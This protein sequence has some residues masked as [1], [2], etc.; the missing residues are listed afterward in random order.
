MSVT[1]NANLSL[2]QA[3]VK[4]ASKQVQSALNSVNINPK[5]LDKFGGALG[6][7]T[8]NA[9]EFQKSM[10]AATARVFA[11]GATAAVIQSI[12]QSFKA[13]VSTTIE[14]EKRLVEINTIFGASEQTFSR[15]RESIFQ[16]AK[17]TGQAFDVVAEG[18][19]ELARQGLNAEETA[20]RLNAA[21]VLTR[22]SGLDSVSSV[23]ALTAAINGFTSASLDATTIVNKL[24]AVDTA[25]AVS[26]KDLAD[27]FQRAG[28]TAEDAGVSFD[29]LLGI[30]TAVQQ[31]TSRGGAVI[32]NAL[33]SIFT[34]LSRSTTISELQELGVQIDANQ[35]G[36][37]KLK[38][39]SAALENVS[40]PTV[41]SQIKELAGGVFQINV[42]SAALKD[43]SNE[44]SI[45]AGA[46][47]KAAGAT[48]EAFQKNKDLNQTLSAQINSLVAG[49]TNL[50]EK[51][52]SITLSPLLGD[53]INIANNITDFF[54][55]ALSE[56]NGN[57]FVK[58]FFAGIGA[59]IKGPGLILIT[60]AFLNIFKLVSKFALDGFKELTK[61]GKGSEKIKNIEQGIIQ[62][63][64]Q[65]KGLRE[66]LAN[67]SL[68]QAQKEEL[69]IKAI[70]QENNLLREQQRIVTALAKAAAARGVGGFNAG[71][72]FSGKRGKNFA[73]GFV[74]SF[75]E[76][77][78]EQ[79]LASSHGYKAGKVRKRRMFDGQGGSFAGIY[80]DAE[81][82]TDVTMGGKKGTFVIPPNGFAA[83]GFVPNFAIRPAGSPKDFKTR[84]EALKAGFSGAQVGRVFGPAPKKTKEKRKDPK[85]I[86][87]VS[88]SDLGV[89][90]LFSEAKSGTLNGTL[91]V[92]DY[93]KIKKRSLIKPKAL[94]DTISMTGIQVRSLGQINKED[95]APKS[96]SQNID[97][98]FADPLEKFAKQIGDTLK[99]SKQDYNIKAAIDK[100]DSQPS[101]LFTTGVQ[102]QLFESAARIAA[103]G[104][105]NAIK[106]FEGGASE[107]KP[108]DFEENSNALASLAEAFQ[109]NSPLLKADA[110]RTG[111]SKAANSIIRKALNDKSVRNKKAGLKS[112][113]KASGYV[114][115]FFNLGLNDA[116]KR[117]TT[118][119]G[120][121]PSQVRVGQDKAFAASSNPAG[122]AVTNTRD[123]PN[124]ISDVLA[125]SGYVPNFIAGAGI[126]ALAKFGTKN[127]AKN[128][129]KSAGKSAGKKPPPLPKTGG[130]MDGE[131]TPKTGGMM[132]GGRGVMGMMALSQI[133]GALTTGSDKFN[134]FLS[135][136]KF[137]EINEE[138]EKSQELL[139]EI[140]AQ[141]GKGSEEYEKQSKI[142]QGLTKDLKAQKGATNLLGGVASGA[143]LG[144]QF[145][146]IGAAVGA[147]GGAVFS[148][149]AEDRNSKTVDA[150]IAELEKGG[151]LSAIE[152]AAVSMQGEVRFTNDRLGTLKDFFKG[153]ASFSEALSAGTNLVY[154]A[155]GIGAIESFFKTLQVIGTDYDKEAARLRKIELAEKIKEL[156]EG[157]GDIS[158]FIEDAARKIKTTNFSFNTTS[159]SDLR[160]NESGFGGQSS[161]RAIADF[162]NSTGPV[163]R[164]KSTKPSDIFAEDM[165]RANL[166]KESQQAENFQKFDTSLQRL[167][168]KANFSTKTELDRS[169]DLTDGGEA[170]AL[171][172][173][174]QK[175]AVESANNIKELAQKL[176]TAPA[177]N[178]KLIVDDAFKEIEKLE[179]LDI[180]SE[181][182]IESLKKNFTDFN[183]GNKKTLEDFI[184]NQVTA[185]NNKLK[186]EIAANDKFIADLNGSL[187]KDI[188]SFVD[189]QN[190][191]FGFT[192][193]ASQIS[194][195]DASTFL[196]T[197][198]SEFG[199]DKSQGRAASTAFQAGDKTAALRVIS[200]AQRQQTADFLTQTNASGV[201]TKTFS[202]T[203]Q[204]IFNQ[205]AEKS[206]GLETL[207]AGAQEGGILDN[208]S[209]LRIN[210][211]TDEA[212]KATNIKEA[213]AVQTRIAN[214]IDAVSS[215]DPTSERGKAAQNQLIAGLLELS[216]AVQTGM[217]QFSD[218][219]DSAE[220]FG[221]AKNKEQQANNA[222]AEANVGGAPDNT[223]R[224]DEITGKKDS[225]VGFL[226][227]IDDQLIKAKQDQLKALQ[228]ELEK[229]RELD[230]EGAFKGVFDGL[231]KEFTSLSGDLKSRGEGDLSVSRDLNASVANLKGF[232]ESL[233]DIKIEIPEEDTSSIKEV[234]RGIGTS[235][236]E[237]ITRLGQILDR[238]EGDKDGDP[239]D[240]GG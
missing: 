237:S 40:D 17:N 114:P 239:K 170:E 119:T 168:A 160:F 153:Q 217:S 49:L 222:A 50:G 136:G 58:S 198:T 207:S 59:F 62:L 159:E 144:M 100:L 121:S 25:F 190:E 95:F 109:F 46:A 33:K 54:N 47:A 6:R 174:R 118:G 138:L 236:S 36:I 220:S 87:Q 146:P 120:V 147:I 53:L 228:E 72:G 2:N 180:F 212:S 113:F 156:T 169:G 67:A 93:A 149:A 115:N 148:G 63:L 68:S 161:K 64:V 150:R 99:I 85:R 152:R 131:G 70:R 108:F 164:S 97:R 234:F 192:G 56:E 139:M 158:G 126:A 110:K 204:T 26:A 122:L 215:V 137:S 201:S 92:S 30:I 177:S 162:I 231:T 27:G 140:E 151:D 171:A 179:Q 130:K 82:V 91:K 213:A 225:K 73:S 69:L 103:T 191:G 80:N 43:L 134:D 224:G 71:G 35:G 16:V 111:D 166:K 142:V 57:A 78:M 235:F 186:A 124:G 155:S 28:S 227:E 102:G 185:F 167:F 218:A 1:I 194:D 223:S 22:V 229:M 31:T 77:L 18:A 89:V 9:S 5:S 29:E 24:I 105:S 210:T 238:K 206:A 195:G 184:K 39:L 8:G 4:N 211:L 76:S 163:F 21:L 232:T 187:E 101:D 133:S 84:E 182:E 88:G 96:V 125:A 176:E 112:I 193:L 226:T 183:A 79:S 216:K 196:K 34:R 141:S 117:E 129:A 74:P 51:I 132:E 165:T 60:G 189:F 14:V 23:N 154:Q 10:E 66:Q 209:R 173:Q 38:A 230:V 240:V 13:L 41:A 188:T 200:D 175:D 208:N 81:S 128:A 86:I 19:A 106:K 221:A 202:D 75:G 123:E 181:E 98:I 135:G 20:K 61:L 205:I 48:N 15:F 44:S 233:A 172:E 94:N 116:I 199:L 145:G 107:Q 203:Q 32:G 214:E 65:D 37:E 104:A 219:A 55:D 3:S 178:Q 52:G 45:F 83:K 157:I 197:A 143:S 127:L 42:V 7:I 90:S 12:N 11:F